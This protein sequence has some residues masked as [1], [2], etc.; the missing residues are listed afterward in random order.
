MQKNNI[1]R[2]SREVRVKVLDII[3]NSKASHIGSCLSS[4]ELLSVLYHVIKYSP[5]DPKWCDR[6]RFI[7]SKGHAAAVLYVILNKK[8]FI[9]DEWLE[10]YCKNG[11]PLIGHVTHNVPGVE[12]STGSLGHGLPIACGMSIVAKREKR[13]Y[14]IYV[15]LSDGECDEGSIWEAAMF[16]GHH[17]LDN[18]VVLV[19]YNKIQ[20]YGFVKEVLSLEPFAAKW[21]AF[22]WNV[23]EIDGHDPN[24]IT[25]SLVEA[26][27]QQGKP[28]VI[29][30]HTVK[31]K[32][33][34]F[35]E[36]QIIWHYKSPDKEQYNKAM[37]ELKAY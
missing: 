18:M 21:E 25:Q 4:V 13:P 2:F 7:L 8:G 16:A 6:D 31:G 35:M 11:A 24:A 10:N 15:L 28:N 32:G 26:S 29:L 5:K 17:R 14:K 27:F 9:P 22:G 34:S 36:H 1:L 23:Q 37:I 33:V 12:V 3:Y 19:D 30:A 20:S